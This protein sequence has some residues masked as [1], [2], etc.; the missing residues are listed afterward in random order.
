MYNFG[1]FQTLISLL[2]SKVFPQNFCELENSV[3]SEK[4]QN[5]D[6][7]TIPK[8]AK[9]KSLENSVFRKALI[10]KFYTLKISSEIQLKKHF[11]KFSIQV[12]LFI[13]FLVLPF[14][15][16][17]ISYPLLAF[18]VGYDGNNCGNQTFT[19]GT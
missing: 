15:A 13:A 2:I 1:Y 3:F 6:N 18:I 14:W 19:Q 4:F 5:F 7:R 8:L 12:Y 10:L 11:I 17:I 9:L 16:D